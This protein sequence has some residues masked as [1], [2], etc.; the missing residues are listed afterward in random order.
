MGNS[1]GLILPKELL[2]RLGLQEGDE[3]VVSEGPQGSLSI[4]RHT[5]DDEETMRIAR[6]VMKEYHNT[7]RT[8][9]K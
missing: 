7:L 8:L 4:T 6:E 2:N 9:S 5:D 1:T 3:L